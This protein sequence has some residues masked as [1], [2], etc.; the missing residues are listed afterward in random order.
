MP[1]LFACLTHA[2]RV[3]DRENCENRQTVNPSRRDAKFCIWIYEI[4]LQPYLFLSIVKYWTMVYYSASMILY[5]VRASPTQIGQRLWRIDGD[6]RVAETP[7]FVHPVFLRQIP[8]LF[9]LITN[10]DMDVMETA[11]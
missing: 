3:H 6:R 4:G 2:Y 1:Q 7:Y 8:P 11:R 10:S 5:S 9:L